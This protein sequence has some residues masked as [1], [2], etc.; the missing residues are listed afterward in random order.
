MDL[1]IAVKMLEQLEDFKSHPYQD[2]AKVWTI[3]YGSTH[4]D[5]Q[6][7]TAQTLPI[8]SYS[9]YQELYRVVDTLALKLLAL[10]PKSI[11]EQQVN[12]LVVLVYNIG[13]GAF[14]QSSLLRAINEGKSDETIRA[15]W[16]Q[17]DKI[18]AIHNGQTEIKT[19]PGLVTRRASE[20]AIYL[21]E[22]G[23]ITTK[24]AKLVQ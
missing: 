2:S 4:I 13:L 10:L 11:T 16:S 18:K 15:D 24:I 5:G 14:E 20:I 23:D 7:V 17:Y 6:L 8:S 12:A 22:T 3:G 1:S 19:L 9:A 21:N